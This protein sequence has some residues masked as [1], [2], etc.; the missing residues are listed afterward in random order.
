MCLEF[1]DT[2]IGNADYLG[3]SKLAK[4]WVSF[5]FSVQSQMTI[6]FGNTPPQNYFSSFLFVIQVHISDI[7]ILKLHQVPSW[8]VYG[9]CLYWSHIC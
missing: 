6:G 1:D 7:I 5:F 4:F 8:N 3:D 9:R 2:C